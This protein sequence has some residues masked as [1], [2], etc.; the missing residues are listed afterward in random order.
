MGIGDGGGREGNHILLSTGIG[1]PVVS[2]VEV[3]VTKSKEYELTCFMSKRSGLCNARLFSVQQM[4]ESIVGVL[5]K[6]FTL[7]SMYRGL[8]YSAQT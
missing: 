2:S 4:H 5:G 8:L 6:Y 3:Q 1:D 7:H